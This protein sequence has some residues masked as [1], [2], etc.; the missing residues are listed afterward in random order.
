MWDQKKNAFDSYSRYLKQWIKQNNWQLNLNWSKTREWTF[1]LCFPIY[2]CFPLPCLAAVFDSNTFLAHQ[3]WRRKKH[4]KYKMEDL[5][6]CVVQYYQNQKHLL[7]TTWP[8]EFIVSPAWWM[9]RTYIHRRD[10]DNTVSW[11]L[12]HMYRK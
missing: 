11:L 9:L 2:L 8:V 1:T 3:A 6:F 7:M 5:G 4:K 10:I 12:W